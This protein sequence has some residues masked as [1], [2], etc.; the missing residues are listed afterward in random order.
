MEDSFIVP[1]LK[2]RAIALLK[3]LAPL[4][5]AYTLFVA[6]RFYT[7]HV[8]VLPVCAQLPGLRVVVA[9]GTV[10]LLALACLSYRS[11]VRIWRSGESPAPG[12]SVLFKRRIVKGWRARSDAAA[13]LFIAALSAAALVAFLRFFVFSEAG[14]F[15]L[16]LRSCEP[17]QFV[18]AEP[19]SRPGA[20]RNRIGRVGLIQASGFIPAQGA[21]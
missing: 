11:A 20:D 7:S 3:V 17:R 12:T 8:A 5:V 1:T 21:P 19:A 10:V 18:Q 13:A 9:T 6:A 4:V 16:G 14:Q 15:I 2:Q